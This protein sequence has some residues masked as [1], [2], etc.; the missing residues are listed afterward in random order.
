MENNIF[1]ELEQV[2]KGVSACQRCPLFATANRAVAGEGNPNA[3]IMFIGEAPGKNEDLTGRPFVGAAGKLLDGMLLS[4]GLARED[5]YI[6]SI[7]K[8]RPPGNRDPSKIE[9]EACFPW[10]QLQ[11]ELI[12]PFIIVAL[13]RHAMNVLLPDI[14]QISAVHG[15]VFRRPDEQI[16]IPFYHPAAALHQPGLKTVIADD[17]QKLSKIIESNREVASKKSKK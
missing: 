6:T 10:L 12:K 3:E 17:F 2:S 13:G 11:I 8:H 9:I 5:V 4:I 7:V 16:C 15:Q 1:R 14:G